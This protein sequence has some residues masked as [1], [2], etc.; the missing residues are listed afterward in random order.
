MTLQKFLCFLLLGCL[1]SETIAKNAYSISKMHTQP[2][3]AGETKGHETFYISTV[4]RTY[5]LSLT[6]HLRFSEF[7]QI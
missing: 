4:I 6:M 3:T 1:A 2:F 7:F 5:F